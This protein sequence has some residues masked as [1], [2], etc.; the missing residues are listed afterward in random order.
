MV[1][2]PTVRKFS[3]FDAVSQVEIPSAGLWH[4]RT[5][6][7]TIDQCLLQG[8]L[9]IAPLLL[10]SRAVSAS[11]FNSNAAPLRAYLDRVKLG[12]GRKL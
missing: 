2:S 4:Q 8:N 12:A 10:R 7:R 6:V 1:I 5:T 9:I 11:V 3:D